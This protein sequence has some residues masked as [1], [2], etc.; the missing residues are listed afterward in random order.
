MAGAGPANVLTHSWLFG[1]GPTTITFS[2]SSVQWRQMLS[3][4]GLSTNV[5]N[6]LAGGNSSGYQPFGAPGL[7]R[8]GL[9]PTAQFVGG[10][11]WMMSRE[12]GTLSITLVNLYK[13]V[14]WRL[15]FGR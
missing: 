8:S 12:N 4:P 2:P 9:N 10:R 7:R 1:V 11:K 5:A 3:A 6:F 13:C 15:P 14:F